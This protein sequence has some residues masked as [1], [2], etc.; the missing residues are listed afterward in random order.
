MYVASLAV[1][2][3]LCNT[4]GQSNSRFNAALEAHLS[5]LP[6]SSTAYE[7][8]LA[9]SQF[10][11]SWLAQEQERQQIYNAEWRKRNWANITLEARVKYQKLRARLGLGSST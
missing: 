9:M 10:Y 5:S 2:S 1:L 7:K 11:G 4:D 3:S 6:P 8:E